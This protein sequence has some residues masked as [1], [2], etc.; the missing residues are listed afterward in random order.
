MASKPHKSQDHQRQRNRNK[1]A[2]WR[3]RN[4]GRLAADL[5]AKQ[6]AAPPAPTGKWTFFLGASISAVPKWEGLS[7]WAS[8]FRTQQTVCLWP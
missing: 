2:A 4:A 7:K 8:L 3:K 1:V 6:M 5:L